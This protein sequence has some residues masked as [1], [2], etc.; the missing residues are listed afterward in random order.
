MQE[1]LDRRSR[2]GDGIFARVV[3]F[4]GGH[5]RRRT[6]KIGQ[7]GEIALFQH[8][9]EGFLVGQHILPELRAE[10]CQPLVN[11]RETLLRGFFQRGTG[12]HETGMI[13]LQNTGLLGVEIQSSRAACTDR[14]FG[15][16]AR[17]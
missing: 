15:R 12:A 17:G 3:A 13:T 10:T 7:P 1:R 8:H 16:R 9:C 2:Q 14:Q 5:A 11:S 4:V 6:G